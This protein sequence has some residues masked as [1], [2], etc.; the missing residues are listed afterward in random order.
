[1]R[2]LHISDL[3][4]G[5]HKEP[6]KTNVEDR[7]QGLRPDLILATGDFAH[8]P[9]ET[10]LKQALAHLEK[11]AESC[12]ASSNGAGQPRLIAVPGNHDCGLFGTSK[13]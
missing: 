6:L 1:M 3:H 2:I 8:H 13:R 4:F 9:E 5:H 11:L 12:P 10:L 7:I